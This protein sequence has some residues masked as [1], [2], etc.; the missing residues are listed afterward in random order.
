MG[1]KLNV[2]EN[3]LQGLAMY[4]LFSILSI[5]L[6]GR[7]DAIASTKEHDIIVLSLVLVCVF[8]AIYTA[9]SLITSLLM[10]H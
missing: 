4:S 5:N 7:P 8:P 3:D 10:T 1:K 9:S 6:P 2:R